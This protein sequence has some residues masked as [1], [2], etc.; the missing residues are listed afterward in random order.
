MS[1]SFSLPLY[2][3]KWEV[4]TR[5]E[6]EEELEGKK[7][8]KERGKKM[9]LDFLPFRLVRRSGKLKGTH[10]HKRKLSFHCLWRR[11]RKGEGRKGGGGREDED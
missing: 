8:R 7:E 10:A 6:R 5:G 9:T 3:A 4:E 2:R 11:K 1:F